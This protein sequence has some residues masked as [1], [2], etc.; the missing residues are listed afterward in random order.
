MESKMHKVKLKDIAE[1]SGVGVAS[2]SAALNGTGRI[3]DAL[4]NRIAQIAQEMDYSPN[5]AAKLLKGKR[6]S[7]IGM[8]ISEQKDI[9]PGSG[10]F[11]GLLINFI[12]ACDRE[13]IKT[14]IEFSDTVDASNRIPY[15]L[16]GGFAGGMIHAGVVSDILQEWIN[17]RN[18]PMVAIDEPHTYSVWSKTGVGVF[19]AAQYLAARGHRQ[20]AYLGGP[21]KFEFHKLGL[22]G[23]KQA[24]QELLLS[25]DD[26]RLI[27][28]FA[29]SG[30]CE[31]TQ[32]GVEFTR[33][34]LRGKKRPTAIICN[35]MRLVNAAVFAITEAGLK[36]PDD[37][38][39]IGNG[40]AWEAER[41][42]PAITAIERDL[43]AIVSSALSIL[44][45]LMDSKNI[46]EPQ[47]WVEPKLVQRNSCGICRI[48]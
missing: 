20:I 31:S 33:Q 35:D 48:K 14:H 28:E 15:F 29:L 1:R 17:T 2:V 9:V 30:D 25:T 5:V 41:I 8:M 16:Y 3:S 21:Q 18:F 24:V 7:D 12:K 26:G 38:S 22:E 39:I 42:Y 10:V 47:I 40:A 37:I 6:S 46:Y 45:R 32:D 27:H 34:L 36:I 19:N 23:F 43:E 13:N 4:R 11:N 44:H